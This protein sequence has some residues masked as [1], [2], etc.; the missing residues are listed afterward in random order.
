MVQNLGQNLQLRPLTFSDYT[1]LSRGLCPFSSLCQTW[2]PAGSG[3]RNWRFEAMS[4]NL[5][6]FPQCWKLFLCML[7]K[8]KIKV[9]VCF[10]SS[11]WTGVLGSL[12]TSL[13]CCLRARIG[14]S[15]SLWFIGEVCISE[16]TSTFVLFL[17]IKRGS[18]ISFNIL[19]LGVHCNIHVI[20]LEYEEK[21]S[22]S[23]LE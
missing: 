10:P 8:D 3:F 9:H 13:Q 14:V 12:P 4:I 2:F 20:S 23:K 1:D 15:L 16:C 11:I 18:G 19:F 21:M 6:W 7:Q 22:L 17:C 5:I